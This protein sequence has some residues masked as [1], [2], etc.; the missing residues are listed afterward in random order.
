[1]NELSHTAFRCHEVSR[2]MVPKEIDKV[3]RC[4]RTSMRC[5]DVITQHIDHVSCHDSQHRSNMA[6]SFLIR[7]SVGR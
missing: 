5:Q 6:R 2:Y 7:Q 4:R 3:V 1:M